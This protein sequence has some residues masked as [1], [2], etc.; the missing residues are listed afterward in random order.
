MKLPRSLCLASSTIRGRSSLKSRTAPT[1]AWVTTSTTAPRTITIASRSTAEDS[2]RLQRSRRS[3]AL[4]TGERTATL[5]RET[6]MTRRTLAIDASAHATATTPAISRIVRIDTETSSWVRRACPAGEEASPAVICSSVRS[7]VHDV[8]PSRRTVRRCP[9]PARAGDGHVAAVRR[10]GASPSTCPRA[11]RGLPS[12]RP[13]AV[14]RSVSPR[15]ARCG[16]GGLL[17]RLELAP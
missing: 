5:K 13:C 4:T 8:L 7:G 15:L 10:R 11:R 16:L 9:S 17:G 12:A 14:S 1:T 2:L 3:I 6:K